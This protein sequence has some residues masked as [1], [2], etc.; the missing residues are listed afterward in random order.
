MNPPINSNQFLLCSC[1]ENWAGND[2]N[3]PVNTGFYQIE[4]LVSI[5]AGQSVFYKYQPY[6]LGFYQHRFLVA[7]VVNS[8]QCLSWKGK[9]SYDC[10]TCLPPYPFELQIPVVNRGIVFNEIKPFISSDFDRKDACGCSTDRGN[11]TWYLELH[12]PSNNSCDFTIFINSTG[13]IF[14]FFFNYRKI[15]FILFFH[16]VACPIAPNGL[17]CSGFPCS[18]NLCECPS[19]RSL[20]DC[21]GIRRDP[22]RNEMYNGI[23]LQ[24]L[25]TPL[26]IDPYNGFAAVAAT[27][28]EISIEVFDVTN[29][30]R[31]FVSDF[32]QTSGNETVSGEGDI[33]VLVSSGKPPEFTLKIT[34]TVFPAV[35]I[36]MVNA[37]Y[38]HL[39]V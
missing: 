4:Q 28:R 24:K 13:K 36:E 8:T 20:L 7:P 38:D 17:E 2:C 29:G 18:E 30:I 22:E 16:L 21:S 12:N 31:G 15:K 27:N 11:L 26:A 39:K 34:P 19:D 35:F 5:S 9:V 3:S 6:G 23:F 14:I 33:K 25:Y 10:Q 1:E 37:T 32:D